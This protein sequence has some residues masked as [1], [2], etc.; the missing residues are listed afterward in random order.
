MLRERV[1]LRIE[2]E[3][4]GGEVGDRRIESDGRVMY[5]Q[6]ISARKAEEGWVAD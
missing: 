3:A 5:A 6:S 4:E 1:E 2:R